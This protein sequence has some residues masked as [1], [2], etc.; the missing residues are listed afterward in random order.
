M[1]T[2]AAVMA[3]QTVSTLCQSAVRRSMVLC[4]GTQNLVLQRWP[5]PTAVEAHQNDR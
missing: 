5:L 1:V 4:L 2:A 3:T